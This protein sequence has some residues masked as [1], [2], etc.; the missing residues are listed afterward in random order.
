MPQPVLCPRADQFHPVF[1]T[2][3]L[4]QIEQVVLHLYRVVQLPAE[5][6]GIGDA[7]GTD[8][9]HPQLD[10]AHGQPGEPLVAQ[11]RLGVRILDDLF[12]DIARFGARDGKDTPL[13]G[14]VMTFDITEFGRFIGNGLAQEITVIGRPGPGGHKVVFILSEP[15]DGIFGARG[16]VDRQRIGQVD[17]P[18]GGQLVAGE[19]IQK[20]SGPRPLD[21]MFGKGGRIDQA[22]ALADRLG[23]ID[24]M[25]PPAAAPEG[26]A[27]VVIEPQ[28]RKVVRAFPPVH[29]AELCATGGLTV[30]GR[31]GT[32]GPT[33]GALLIRVV[34][35]IDVLIGLFVLARGIFGGHP[36]AIAFGV[37]R[38]HVDLGLALDHHL[39]KVVARAPRSCDPEREPFGQPHIAQPGCRT[40]QRVAVGRIADRPVE[41]VLEAG[42]RTRRDAVGHG[43]IL[44]RDPV[45]IQREKIGPEAVRHP[46]FEPCR[47]AA[48]VDAQNPAAPLFAGVGFIV[49]V[50]HN[51]MLRIAVG[52]PFDQLGVLIHHDKRMFNRNGRHLDA[53]HLGG[54]LC[55]VAAGGNNMFGSDHD[56][57][58]RGDKVPALLDHLGDGNLPRRAIP[59]KGIRLPLALNRH[60]PLPRALGH[61]HGDIGGVNVAVRLVVQRAFQ[62]VG[63]DQ[64]PFCLD[65]IRRHEGIGH[66]AGLGGRGIEHVFVHAFVRLRHAQVAHHGKARVQAGLFLKRLV[67]LD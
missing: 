56:L 54:A 64:R 12:Q 61:R 8:R 25:L 36:V 17:A 43:H 14:H 32:Q 47:R 59:V 65:L 24:R 13:R 31:R 27:V 37:Q 67:E 63:L 38:R 66:A 53:Q 41:I 60:P 49:G 22:H 48:L 11:H 18:G 39:R 4:Q 21:Q 57:L 10:I 2:R 6:S 5:L 26:P 44:I 52:A 30:I 28:R 33:R 46:I 34:Q 1:L 20:G 35:D 19:P 29:M 7:D 62:I 15:H 9:D 45:Q 16:A 3:L 58:V 51:R 55:V 23:L 40:D 42:V 50:T